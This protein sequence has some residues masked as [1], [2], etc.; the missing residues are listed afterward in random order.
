MKIELTQNKEMISKGFYFEIEWSDKSKNYYKN[1]K[2]VSEVIEKE[3]S[4]EVQ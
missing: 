1:I 4:N 2:E 3:F